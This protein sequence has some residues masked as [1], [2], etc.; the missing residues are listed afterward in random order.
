MSEEK[1]PNIADYPLVEGIQH[2]AVT[3]SNIVSIGFDG[4]SVIEVEFRG[5]NRYQ[6]YGATKEL[7]ESFSN[8]ESKGKFFTA[9]LRCMRFFRRV[10]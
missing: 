4:N 5:G 8:S 7:W 3:S 6:Y 1:I 9:N 2:Q 10:K